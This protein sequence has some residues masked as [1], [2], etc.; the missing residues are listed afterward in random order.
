[1]RDLLTPGVGQSIQPLRPR[2]SARIEMVF[3]PL[4]SREEMS[5]MQIKNR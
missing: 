4:C 5:L 1:M 3:E 2:G